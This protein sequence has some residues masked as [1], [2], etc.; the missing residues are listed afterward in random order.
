MRWKACSIARES[1]AEKDA[2]FFGAA[3]GFGVLLGSIANGFRFGDYTLM[4]ICRRRA[5]E[6]GDVRQL[7]KTTL[8]TMGGSRSG[9]LGR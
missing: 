1:L 7:H 4:S 2:Y 5:M 9:S 6:R 3:R 8:Y